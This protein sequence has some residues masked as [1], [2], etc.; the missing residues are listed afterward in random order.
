M[1]VATTHLPRD[2]EGLVNLM[3]AVVP[4]GMRDLFPDSMGGLIAAVWIGLF[5]V[6]RYLALL[7]TDNESASPYRGIL[8]SAAAFL[9]SIALGGGALVLLGLIYLPG[10]GIILAMGGVPIS[11][12]AGV[13]ARLLYRGARGD[14]KPA[15]TSDRLA[16][17]P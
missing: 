17:T 16:R 7:G 12:V 9:G 1:A 10:Y 15:D 2:N 4:H 14:F 8:C 3:A 11:L 13:V 6:L 5:W